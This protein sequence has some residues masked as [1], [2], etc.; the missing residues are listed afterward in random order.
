MFP[1][2]IKIKKVAKKT[3]NKK[4][5]DSPVIFVRFFSLFPVL[6]SFRVSYFF[7]RFSVFFSFPFFVL[8]SFFRFFPYFFSLTVFPVPFFYRFFFA[9]FPSGQTLAPPPRWFAS[10]YVSSSNSLQK[11]TNSPLLSHHFPLEFLFQFGF[12]SPDWISI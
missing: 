1:S 2:S 12:N 5:F 6:F 11:K 9:V 3:Q 10:L 7:Q 8:F 4:K